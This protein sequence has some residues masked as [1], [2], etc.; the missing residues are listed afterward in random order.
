VTTKSESFPGAA[1]AAQ[2]FARLEELIPD[3]LAEMRQDL[4]NHPLRREFVLLEGRSTYH[5]T[6][7]FIYHHNDHLDLDGQVRILQNLGL[8]KIATNDKVPRY[9]MQENLVEY[10]TDEPADVS[11]LVPSRIPSEAQKEDALTIASRART[12][13]AVVDPILKAK[14][15]TRGKWVTAAGVG[16]NSVYEYLD[17]KRSLTTQN[18][19]AMADVLGLGTEELPE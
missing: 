4:M 18:R 12:R 9:A 16:N 7:V 11:T 15:W 5:G 2:Q 8:V 6:G 17:G 14:G 1:P 10:L 13:H 3:L 19:K